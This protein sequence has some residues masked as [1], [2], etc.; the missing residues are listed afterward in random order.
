MGDHDE[1]SLDDLDDRLLSLRERSVAGSQP[2]AESRQALYDV[3]DVLVTPEILEKPGGVISAVALSKAQEQQVELLRDIV[4][5]SSQADA[6]SGRRLLRSAPAFSLSAVPRILGT[7]IL[8]LLVSLPF[9]SSDFSEGELPP[10]DFDEDR[11]GATTVY[12]LLDNLTQD[13]FV[14][15][16]S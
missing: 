5:G 12:N 7:G 8:L 9:V 4:G 13:D 1:R 16:G 14:L 15:I 10:S 11:H 3:D 6:P 2:S